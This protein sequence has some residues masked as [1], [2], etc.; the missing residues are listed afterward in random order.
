MKKLHQ[1][2]IHAV[3]PLKWPALFAGPM[4]FTVGVIMLI[5][6]LDGTFVS[7]DASP[8]L[9]GLVTLFFIVLGG[10]MFIYSLIIFLTKSKEDD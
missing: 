3:R 10:W 2:F 8:W 9:M 5:K 1:N 6:L 7:Q 4:F